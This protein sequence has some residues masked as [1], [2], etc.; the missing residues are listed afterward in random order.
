MVPASGPTIQ[1]ADI[2]DCMWP[3]TCPWLSAPAT[4]IAPASRPGCTKPKPAPMTP[5]PTTR[6][7]RSAATR[8]KPMPLQQAATPTIVSRCGDI[9]SRGTTSAWMTK[10][11]VAND[12][13]TKLA[14]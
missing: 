13:D 4:C 14:Y 3:A 11:Q 10:E 2:A 6:P 12:A 1:A 8:Q 7:A 5:N 9:V